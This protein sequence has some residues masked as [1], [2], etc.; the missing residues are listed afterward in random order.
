MKKIAL[1]SI[2]VFQCFIIS[3]NKIYAK[4]YTNN[5]YRKDITIKDIID[6]DT[7]K[8]TYH[9]R[10]EKVRLSGIDAPERGKP[11]YRE[12]KYFLAS[13]ITNR[14]VSI[15]VSNIGTGNRLVAIVFS[16]QGSGNNRLNVNEEL[17]KAG[18]AV[19]SEDYCEKEYYN[20]W[21]NL[22]EE[23]KKNKK[24]FWADEQYYPQIEEMIKKN[25]KKQKQK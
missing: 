1:F 19:V 24:V 25:R 23:A 5:H 20:K 22:Q 6:G 9:K 18:L 21:I 7:F 14:P 12:A 17:I 13:I 11:Y 8:T 16:G 4:D 2:F 10:P 15:H 3:Q